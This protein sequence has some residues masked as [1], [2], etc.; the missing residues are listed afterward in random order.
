MQH[1]KFDVE[2][3]FIFNVM[4]KQRW[5]NAEMLTGII[6]CSIWVDLATLVANFIFFSAYLFFL[7]ISEK[8]QQQQNKQTTIVFWVSSQ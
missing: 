3:C 4:L 8:K 7:G 2:F 6:T 1:W 5:Y